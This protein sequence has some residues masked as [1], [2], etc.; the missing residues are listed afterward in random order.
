MLILSPAPVLL[1]DSSSGSGLSCRLA[2]D[3]LN[4]A[5]DGFDKQTLIAAS[6]QL[7]AGLPRLLPDQGVAGGKLEGR[8]GR[9]MR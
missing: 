3:T 6:H 1:P 4:Q 9:R 8:V 7:T 5:A 2:L